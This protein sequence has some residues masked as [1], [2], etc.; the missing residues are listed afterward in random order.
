MDQELKEVIKKMLRFE[1][2]DRITIDELYL[3]PLF[4]SEIS[5][6]L[7]QN[8]EELGPTNIESITLVDFY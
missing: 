8:D 6:E 1:E 5:G 2:K 3:N 4:R 7:L